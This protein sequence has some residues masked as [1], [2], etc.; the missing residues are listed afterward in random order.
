MTKHL[1]PDPD[2]HALALAWWGATGAVGF[3]CVESLSLKYSDSLF[4]TWAHHWRSVYVT[5]FL[6]MGMSSFLDVLVIFSF[7]S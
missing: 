2:E 6:E 3:V 7:R 5:G 4:Q 1:F